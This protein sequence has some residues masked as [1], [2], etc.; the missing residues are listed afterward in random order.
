[1]RKHLKILQSKIL[2]SEL[3]LRH[4]IKTLPCAHK[5]ILLFLLALLILSGLL[6]LWQIDKNLSIE[7]PTEGGTIR[8][9]II[10]TP[11]FV[12]PALTIS[13]ADRDLTMLVYSGLT[14][15]KGDELILDLAENY[16]ISENG[17]CYTFTLKPNLLWSDGAPLTSDDI[18]FT[19]EQIKNPSTKSPKRANWEGVNAEKIDE[20]TINF[21]LEK[22]YA[23]F[24]EN[25]TLGIL[26]LHVWKNVLPEQMP[27]SDFNIKAIGSGPYKIEKITR[28]SSGIISS[29]ALV[30]NKNFSLRA[31]FL[32]KII[33]KFYPSEKD[34]VDAY[35]QKQIDG[36]SA[37]SPEQILEIKNKDALLKTYFLSRIFAF[38]FNQD[39]APVFT[40]K[41]V[42]EALNLSVDK[43]KIVSEVLQNFG[44]AINGPIPPGSIGHIEKPASE[45]NFEQRIEQAKKILE[46]NGWELNQEENVMEKKNKKEIVKLEFSISTSNMPDLI[47][48]S[49]ILKEDWEKIGAK[50]RIKIYEIGDLE[51]NVIRPRKYDALLFGEIMGRDPDAFAFWHSSQRNDPGLNIAL[52]ANI[53]ADKILEEVRTIFDAQKKEKKYY[54]FQKEIEKDTPAIFLYSP[55]FIHLLP[56]SLKGVNE[57]S[58]TISSERFSQV[59]NWYTNTKK[60][61]KIFVN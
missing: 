31:P 33:L 42:R 5:K 21:C 2:L 26:P 60:I 10:G 57:S 9:G 59:Y 55:Y 58:I 54:E 19:I 8:E 51:Q 52:Y 53:A 18:I 23:P 22:P 45:E 24:L 3:R 47:K 15:A 38:F 29:C 50:A 7:V 56:S 43:E 4:A 48:I 44:A 30:P 14:R 20:R 36:L 1:M 16:E 28:S 35:K 13:D 12:N 11:R 39:N 17:Q 25:T 46:K 41:E 6:L 37:I 40:K 61:W 32:K 49:N 27:L 34:L